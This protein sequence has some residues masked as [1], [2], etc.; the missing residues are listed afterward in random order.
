MREFTDS[1]TYVS[2]WLSKEQEQLISKYRFRGGH[3][4]VSAFEPD[5]RAECLNCRDLGFVYVW[6]CKDGPFASPPLGVGKWCDGGPGLKKGWYKVDQ[7]IALPC[8]KCRIAEDGG[9]RMKEAAERLN[10]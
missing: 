1:R 4:F 8:P 10:K 9:L 7:H 6:F 3:V 5:A 2:P